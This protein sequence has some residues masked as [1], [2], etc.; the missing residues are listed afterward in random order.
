[1]EVSPECG[2]RLPTGKSVGVSEVEKEDIEE[3]I[4]GQRET[5]RERDTEVAG[6]NYNGKQSKTDRM[7][8]D[9]RSSSGREEMGCRSASL[10]VCCDIAGPIAAKQRKNERKQS[11][12]YSV[13]IYC[14]LAGS[15]GT[16]EHSRAL[17]LQERLQGRRPL[18]PMFQSVGEAGDWGGDRD[19]AGDL[20][21]RNK[22]CQGCGK[23]ISAHW[24]IGVDLV[25]SV[26][27]GGRC[28]DSR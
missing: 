24:E 17:R 13:S 9:Q 23:S 15:S 21:R 10:A 5:K 19:F 3:P 28:R 12:G 27:S 26:G 7:D 8:S 1:M 25:G 2:E 16:L 6:S 11:N 14:V 18:V 20:F 22:G 4:P